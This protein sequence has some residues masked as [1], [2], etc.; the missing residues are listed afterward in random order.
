MTGTLAFLVLA[1]ALEVGGDAAVRKGL[2]Q[3]AWPWLLLG[4]ATLAAY[5]VVV[6]TNRSIDFGRLMGVYIAVF[7]TV[8]QVISALFFGEPLSRSI[9]VGGLLIAS[10]GVVLA[11]GAAR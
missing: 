6:N 4:M 5:G 8:S 2:V 1:A 9:L 7:F 10:G 3:S 11:L